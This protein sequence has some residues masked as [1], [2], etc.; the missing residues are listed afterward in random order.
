MGML[1][2]RYRNAKPQEE[3][4]KDQEVEQPQEE[5][6]KKNRKGRGSKKE[7]E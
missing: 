4:V 6:V 7:V 2:K 3:E 5:E 1:L